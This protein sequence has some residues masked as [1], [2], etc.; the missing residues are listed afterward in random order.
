MCVCVC[1]C[2]APHTLLI[3]KSA[4]AGGISPGIFYMRNYTW[5]NRFNAQM[6]KGKSEHSLLMIR[7]ITAQSPVHHGR[8]SAFLAL[9]R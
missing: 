8:M 2:G 6:A 9:P 3:F 4:R 5:A 7:L 1:V